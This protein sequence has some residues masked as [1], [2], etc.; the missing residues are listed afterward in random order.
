MLA[1]NAL[2]PSTETLLHAAQVFVLRV[3]DPDKQEAP[4]ETFSTI[5]PTFTEHLAGAHSGR[6]YPHAHACKHAQPPECFT[7][8]ACGVQ[9]CYR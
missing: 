7:K 6:W 5:V 8:L 4:P 2:K 1:Q 9:C 3:E